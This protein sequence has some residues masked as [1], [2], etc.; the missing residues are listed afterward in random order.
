MKTKRAAAKRIKIT[1]SGKAKIKRSKLRHFLT[2]KT[3]SMKRGKRMPGFIHES[4]M[5]HVKKLL[6]YAF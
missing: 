4:H 5:D 3:T 6:P 2:R 1:A